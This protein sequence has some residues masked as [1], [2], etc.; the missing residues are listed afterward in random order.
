MYSKSDAWVA[1]K[2]KIQG[3]NLEY[4]DESKLEP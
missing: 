4:L 1:K 2:K 3:Y